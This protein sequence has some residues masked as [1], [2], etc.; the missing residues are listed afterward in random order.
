MS[1]KRIFKVKNSCNGIRYVVL[2]FK[3]NRVSKDVQ[4]MV[5][6]LKQLCMNT[7][8]IYYPYPE[9]PIANIVDFSNSLP[10]EVVH[11]L[12]M[13]QKWHYGYSVP[14]FVKINSYR[15]ATINID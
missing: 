10:K 13:V 11:S 4:F 8:V 3:K 2:D 15:T 6:A 12:S 5:L 9:Q 14:V 1:N 7:I